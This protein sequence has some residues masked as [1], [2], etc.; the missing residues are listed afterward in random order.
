[1]TT[2]FITLITTVIE[3]IT[4]PR[5]VDADFVETLE[6][7]QTASL[8]LFYMNKKIFVMRCSCHFLSFR[9]I[10][11]HLSSLIVILQPFLE[12]II[13]CVIMCHFQHYVVVIYI[14]LALL[15]FIGKYYHVVSFT[16]LYTPFIAIFG[17]I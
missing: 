11:R 12:F 9:V 17:T 2:L 3:S 4:S 5:L 10:Y 7:S 13:L 6:F 14:I 16:V 15:K 8:P 1:M